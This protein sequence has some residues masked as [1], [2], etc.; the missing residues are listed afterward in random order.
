MMAVAA[1]HAYGIDV[2]DGC[3]TSSEDMDALAECAQGFEMAWTAR[4]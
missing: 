2:L 4:P 1:A 3:G